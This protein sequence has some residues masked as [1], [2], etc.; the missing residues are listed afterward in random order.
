MT[1]KIW[2][3]GCIEY[4]KYKMQFKIKGRSVI[5]LKQ[6]KQMINL[7]ILSKIC[8]FALFF[9]II[10]MLFQTL[11]IVS[12][13]SS[14]FLHKIMSLA[15]LVDFALR[16]SIRYFIKLIKK[17]LFNP[18]M[19]LSWCFLRFELLWIFSVKLNHNDAT[20]WIAALALVTTV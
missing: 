17:H 7:L 4:V 9:Y 19:Q 15:I 18:R 6:F 5:K 10:T 13:A 16:F 2:F 20:S 3:D 12:Q 1:H 14:H 11:Y 8:T